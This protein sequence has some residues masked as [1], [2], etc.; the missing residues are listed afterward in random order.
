MTKVPDIAGVLGIEHS[1]VE[2]GLDHLQRR[3]YVYFKASQESSKTIPI[4]ITNKGRNALRELFMTEPKPSN[5]AVCMDALTG[6][7]YRSQPLYQPREIRELEIHQIPTYIPIPKLEQIDFL[8]LKRLVAETQKDL[9]PLSEKR[10]LV[11]ILEIE[12]NW[13]AYRRMRILQ[14]VR[15]TDGAVLV[16]V[17][18]RGDRSIEHEAALINMESKK[19]RPLRAVKQIDVPETNL[20]DFSVIDTKKLEAA[21]QIAIEKP[22]IKH[23]INE[24][25]QLLEQ[26]RNLQSSEVVQERRQA[27]VRIDE[28]NEQIA[29]LEARLRELETQAGA[30]EVL[31]MY[32]H[33]PK[34]IEALRVAKNQVIIVS[35]WLK[36]DAVDDELRQEMKKTLQRGV[37]ISI[38]YGFG[39]ETVAEKRTV[40]KL[41]ELA[42]NKKGKLKLSRVGNLHSKVL[43]CDQEFMVLTSFNWLSFAGDPL[44]GTRIEDGML[45][46]DK[47]AIGEKTQEWI[48]RMADVAVR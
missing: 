1:T 44:R 25:I 18:D 45:T 4:L 21:R 20:H 24:K 10:E 35:P 48:S 26:E 11:D 37:N 36:S 32:E 41:Q 39:D 47:S 3:D 30:I 17:F 33:R 27:N 43:I 15:E 29:S 16:Q 19:L 5:Y 2:A 8:S 13:T 14:Y 9:P 38:A 22:K 23:D 6:L 28:L 42:Q 7:L 12:K 34:L 40:K 46:R 31:Q